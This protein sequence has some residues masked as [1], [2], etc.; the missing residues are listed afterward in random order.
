MVTKSVVDLQITNE[1]ERNEHRAG[2]ISIGSNIPMEK[3]HSGWRGHANNQKTGTRGRKYLL[4]K[5]HK[6]WD[7]RK[8]AC[9]IIIPWLFLSALT[10]MANLNSRQ[11]RSSKIVAWWLIFQKQ[12]NLLRTFFSKVLEVNAYARS[13]YVID[14]TDQYD[15]EKFAMM[16]LQDSAYIWLK[17]WYIWGRRTWEW[18]VVI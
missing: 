3:I 4:R 12:A 14:S 16:M 7:W 6:W 8:E 13:C 10:T 5:S 11:Q 2:W 17:P 15:D 18:Y 9:I 1:R